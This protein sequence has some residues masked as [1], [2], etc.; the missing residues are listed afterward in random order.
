MRIHADPDPDPQ[1]CFWTAKT[2]LRKLGYEDAATISF[3]YT[4]QVPSR[5]S[6]LHPV[7]RSLRIQDFFYTGT[8]FFPSRI[9]DT[10]TSMEKICFLPFSV[11]INSTKL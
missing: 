3:V 11:A 5:K 7:L 1:H 4:V 6:Y 8:G 9:P 10:K 2:S